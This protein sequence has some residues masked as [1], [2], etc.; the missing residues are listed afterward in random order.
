MAVGK[1]KRAPQK[2]AAVHTT[3]S[4]ARG[5]R[6][7]TPPAS[8]KACLR[9][10]RSGL[11]RLERQIE[12]ASGDAL[13]RSTRLL[14]NVSQL[15]GRLAAASEAE[16]RRS[17]EARLDAVRAVLALE[18]AIQPQEGK[19]PAGKKAR[20]RKRPAAARDARSRRAARRRSGPS[21]SPRRRH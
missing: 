17:N 6:Q 12:T 7:P 19:R 16:W 14:R 3:R 18:N 4:P 20:R 2:A 13:R 9:K 5:E 8:R 15:L 10:L 21:G 11:A 1:R